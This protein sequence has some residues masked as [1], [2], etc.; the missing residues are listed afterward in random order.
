MFCF[1]LSPGLEGL[2]SLDFLGLPVYRFRL[3]LSGFAFVY[4]V[5]FVY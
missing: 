2:K 5:I 1:C 3:G 4:G